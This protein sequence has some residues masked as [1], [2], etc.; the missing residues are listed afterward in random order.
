MNVLICGDSF[1]DDSKGWVTKL[2]AKVTNRSQRGIGEYKIYKQTTGHEQYD[3]IIVCHT[4]PWRIHTP[5]HPVHKDSEQRPN[6]DF[7]LADLNF[8]KGKSKEIDKI[9]SHIT[10]YTDWDYQ[11]F[12]YN[13]IVDK[14][15]T[16]P[17]SIHI[18]FHEPLDTKKIPN[19]YHDVWQKY[20]GDINHLNILGNEIVAKRIQKLLQ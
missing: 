13:M 4:S 7:M 11:K 3:R 1:S 14:L 6:N 17:N 2:Q 20:P 5:L 12:V 19:N 15:F 16:I 9:Y 8:H 18:T 10:K